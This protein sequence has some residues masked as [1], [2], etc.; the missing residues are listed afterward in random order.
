MKRVEIFKALTHV[1]TNVK[2][3]LIA[4]SFFKIWNL[5]FS[6]LPLYLYSFFVNHILSEQNIT[7]L[8][9][10]I[11]GYVAVFVFITI[12][13]TVSKKY[14]NILIFKC[15][16]KIKNKLFKKYTSLNNDAYLVGS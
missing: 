4:L 16:L 6:L 13:I 2:K 11:V 12:G 9:F 1:F 14:Y 5:L 10:A 15:N 7:K 3:P 8:W